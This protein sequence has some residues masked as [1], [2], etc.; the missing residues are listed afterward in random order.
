VGSLPDGLRHGIQRW[1]RLRRRPRWGNLRRFEPFSQSYGIERG[2]PVDRI[3]IE[4]FLAAHAD[5]IRGAVLEI[6]DAAYTRAFGGSRIVSS[7]VLDLDRNNPEATLFADLG[8][9]DS[10]PQERF[11]CVICTQTL[12]LISHLDTA[13][14]NLWNSLRVGG[15]LLLTVP[16]ATRIESSYEHADDL[17]RFTPVG[18]SRLLQ[19][20]LPDGETATS[21]RGNLLTTISYLL[22][23]AAEDLRSEDFS[24]DDPA[25]PLIATARVVR[26]R[27]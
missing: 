7:D 2:R 26:P 1:R 27:R 23:L 13:L 15:V 19:T 6:K 14:S 21:G 20:H 8:S 22:G 5:D 18:L 25:F 11:D 17:W 12:H 16:T 4:Q 24:D 9:P 3:Y 10:L